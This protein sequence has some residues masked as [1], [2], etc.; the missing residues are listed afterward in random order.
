MQKALLPLILA[1]SINSPCFAAPALPA[2]VHSASNDIL[3][4][5]PIPEK[6]PTEVNEAATSFAQA[7]KSKS[8][9]DAATKYR[10]AI[11]KA[12]ALIKTLPRGLHDELEFIKALSYENLGD[13]EN[14]KAAYRTTL[15]MRASNDIALFRYAYLLLQSD[16]CQ[17]ALPLLYESSWRNKQNGPQ[18]NYVIGECLLLLKRDEE[19]LSFF[20]KSATAATTFLPPHR[21]LVEM[22]DKKL[23]AII[24]PEERVEI[25]K[26]VASSLEAIAKQDPNDTTSAI[27]FSKYL[28][29]NADPLL[30]GNKLNQAETFAAKAT[31]NSDYANAE[32]VR[33]YVDILM[34]KK[35]F[36]QASTVLEKGLKKNKKSALL[37]EAKKQLEIEKALQ[38]KQSSNLE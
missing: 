22:Y 19:A 1:T 25:E 33:T 30:G 20:E 28:L 13:I 9:N 38:I 18:I 31:K 36:A 21:R 26:K 29:K 24:I 14:A 2:T 23:S 12:N 10:A 5:L 27:A 11:S 37:I 16:N 32:A 15:A 7:R 4:A 34:R 6:F 17:D 3:T 35:N 8:E